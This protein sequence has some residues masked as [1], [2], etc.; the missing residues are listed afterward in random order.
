MR[1]D[2]TWWG[3]RE[4]AHKELTSS[5]TQEVLT[6]DIKSG[7]M[8]SKRILVVEDKQAKS[9]VCSEQSVV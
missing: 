6:G 8:F 7:A 1:W 3:T 2:Q 5:K 4:K 9:V